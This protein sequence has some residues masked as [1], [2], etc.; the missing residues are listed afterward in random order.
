[1]VSLMDIFAINC[2]YTI[3]INIIVYS[4]KW[5]HQVNGKMNLNPELVMDEIHLIFAGLS[6][7]LSF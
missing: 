3:V 4:I 1:M 7:L 6:I 5:H 2:S